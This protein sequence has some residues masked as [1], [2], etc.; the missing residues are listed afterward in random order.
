MAGYHLQTIKKGKLGTVSKIQEELDEAVDSLNQ[1]VKIMLL[2]ELS[3]LIG[4]VKLV[5]QNCGTTLEAILRNQPHNSS[6]GTLTGLQKLISEA[7]V[8]ETNK[9][10]QE[11]ITK[12]SEI[13]SATAQVAEHFDCSLSDLL[14]MQTVTERAFK[15]GSRPSGE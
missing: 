3:D 7:Q 9:N 8:L 6:H 5:A 1:R 14:A 15:S 10:P 11:L 2:V 13:V 12:L 4:A